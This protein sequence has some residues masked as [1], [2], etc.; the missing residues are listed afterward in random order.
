MATASCCVVME[1][2]VGWNGGLS[3]ASC[4]SFANYFTTQSLNSSFVKIGEWNRL[5]T[6][7]SLTAEKVL[8]YSKLLMY[9]QKFI[10]QL[11]CVRHHLLSHGDYSLWEDRQWPMMHYVK[12]KCRVTMEEGLNLDQWVRVVLQDRGGERQ[13]HSE[14][15]RQG[16]IE[17]ETEERSR[18][19]HWE[20]M[21]KMMERE[22]WMTTG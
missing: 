11:L 16:A 12:R 8:R 13:R 6:R 14:T 10:V 17:I 20:R 1:R 19:R 3:L 21:K 2:S 18:E 7:R 5:V 15:Q 9:S 22:S 4:D